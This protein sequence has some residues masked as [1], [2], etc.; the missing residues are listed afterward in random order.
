MFGAELE[1][2]LRCLVSW[3]GVGYLVLVPTPD[4][5]KHVVKL[6]E[7]QSGDQCSKVGNCSRIRNSWIDENSGEWDN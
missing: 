7:H 5:Q 4:L 2:G 6:E 1:I 3:F